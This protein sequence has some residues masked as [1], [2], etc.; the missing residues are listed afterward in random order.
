MRIS[1]NSSQFI[2]FHH[3]ST[4]IWISIKHQLQFPF[5]IL[6][7]SFRAPPPTADRASSGRIQNQSQF[8]NSGAAMYNCIPPMRLKTSLPVLSSAAVIG[9]ALLAAVLFYTQ[10]AAISQTLAADDSLLSFPIRF[11]VNDTNPLPPA[12]SLTN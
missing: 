9:A 3:F 7:K 11:A 6:W 5:S 8:R 1:H 2:T 12:G 10:R 4:L